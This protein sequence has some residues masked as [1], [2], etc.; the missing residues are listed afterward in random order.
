[1][2]VLTKNCF[3]FS[4]HSQERGSEENASG[5][6]TLMNWNIYCC[7]STTEPNQVVYLEIHKKMLRKENYKLKLL[8]IH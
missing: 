4:F 2:N 3:I 7:Q 6:A 1:M 8:D 5:F